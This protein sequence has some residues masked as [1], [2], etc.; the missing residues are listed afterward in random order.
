MLQSRASGKKWGLYGESIERQNGECVMVRTI[1]I[2][3]L[4]SGILGEKFVKHEYER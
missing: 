1:A 2:V 4:S 3:S